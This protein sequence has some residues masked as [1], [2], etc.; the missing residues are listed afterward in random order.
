MF[1]SGKIKGLIRDDVGINTGHFDKASARRADLL[2][3][4]DDTSESRKA[5]IVVPYGFG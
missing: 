4:P 2:L 1:Y 3:V 5:R